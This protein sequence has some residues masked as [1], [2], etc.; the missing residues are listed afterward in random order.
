MIRRGRGR[1]QILVNINVPRRYPKRY[2]KKWD[3]DF[4]KRRG[5][6]EKSVPQV[7]ELEEIGANEVDLTVILRTFKGEVPSYKMSFTLI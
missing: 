3:K 5:F 4:S 2:A 1:P 6:G 7:D